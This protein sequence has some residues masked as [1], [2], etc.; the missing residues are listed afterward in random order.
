MKRILLGVGTLTWDGSERRSDRYG[1]IT[2]F[3]ENSYGGKIG[4]KVKFNEDNIRGNVGKEGELIFE[5][6]ETRD[7]THIGDLFRGFSPTTPEIGQS[8]KLG[9]GRLVRG[10][11]SWCGITLGLEPSDGRDNDWLNPEALYN[12]HEQTEKLYFIDVNS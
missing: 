10:R 9:E 1:M 6:T 11:T 3:D 5:V 7:S 8:I 2:L 4:P 12:A